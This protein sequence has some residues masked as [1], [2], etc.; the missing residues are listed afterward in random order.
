LVF[1]KKDL[2]L[3]PCIPLFRNFRYGFEFETIEW[4]TEHVLSIDAD[5]IV[6]NEDVNSL[7]ENKFAEIERYIDQL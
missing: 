3:P 6:F 1:S 4:L 2:L 5:Q 7:P